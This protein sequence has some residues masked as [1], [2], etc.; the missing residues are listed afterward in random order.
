MKR[1]FSPIVYGSVISVAVILVVALVLVVNIDRQRR[2]NEITVYRQFFKLETERLTSRFKDITGLHGVIVN[3]P[4]ILNSL[5]R[6]GQGQEP[7]QAAAGMIHTILTNIATIDHVLAAYLLDGSGTCVFSSRNDF[8]GKNYGFRPYF[9][10]ALEQGRATYVAR[11]ITSRQLGIYFSRRIRVGDRLL[12]VAVLKLDPDFFD[13]TPLFSLSARPDGNKGS[14]RVG[15]V[16][17]TGLFVDVA[18]GAIH[19][20]GPMDPETAARIR[21][22]RQM[23]MDDIRPL[24]FAAGTWT[25]VRQAG[26]LAAPA[27]GE[28]YYLFAAPLDST[29][30][31]F[32]HVVRTS[33]FHRNYRQH[34]GFYNGLLLVFGCMLVLAC[35]L[36]FFLERRHRTV[37]RQSSALA[38]SEGKLRLF[39]QAVEQSGNSMVITDREGRIIYVNPYFCENTG[40]SREEVLGENPRILKSGIHDE[41]LYT[42]L[43]QTIT[44]GRTW[45]GTLCNRKKNGE[46]FWEE[47]TISPIFNDHGEITHYIAIK[48]DITERRNISRRLEEESDKLQFVVEYAGFGIAIIIDRRF[49]WVNRSGVKMFGYETVEEVLGQPSE[50]VYPDRESYEM[51]GRWFLDPANRNRIFKKE[52][53]L[54]K[55]DGTIFWVSLNGKALDSSDP[56]RGV[57]WIVDDITRRKRYEEELVRAQREAEAASEMKSRLLANISH[58]IRTPLHGIMGTFDLM[59]DMDLAPE[60]ARLVVS[61]RRAADFL[62]NLLNN[63]LD[64]SKIEAGQLVLDEF[65]FSIREL[66]GEVGEMLSSQFRRKGIRFRYTVDREV[67]RILVADALRIKQIFINLTGNSLKFTSQGEIAVMVSVKQQDSRGVLLLCQ[68]RDT[69]EGIPHGQQDRLFEAFTQADPSMRRRSAGTGLGLSICR[70]LCGL[71]GGR[72]WFESEPGQGTTFFFT[73]TCSTVSRQEEQRAMVTDHMEE[74]NG[75][76]LTILIVDDNEANR[77]ILRIILEQD[78]HRVRNAA[79]GL[80]ALQRMTRERFDLVFMDMQMPVMDG[81]TATRIIRHCEAETFTTDP[82][83][84]QLYGLYDELMQRLHQRIRGSRIPIVALTANAMQDDRERCRRAGMDAYLAKPFQRSQLLHILTTF[85]GT[86]QENDGHDPEADR[87]VPEQD[88]PVRDG[89][90]DSGPDGGPEEEG[91]GIPAMATVRRFLHS[92]YPFSEEQVTTLVTTTL[93]GIGQDLDRLAAAVESGE[94]A[95]IGGIAHKMKGSF[96]NLGLS[97]MAD[98]VAGME[99]ACKQGTACDHGAAMDELR[100]QWRLFLDRA[101]ADGDPAVA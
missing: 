93:Q 41:A 40:F 25:R 87:N 88:P 96:L 43:W 72:I 59:Q 63:L 70:E 77:D 8:I 78:G 82:D 48:E 64:L 76:G 15:L 28:D 56:G 6:I 71:M 65:P 85:F 100:R 50:M 16:T 14:L 94:E 29:D 45:K 9:T 22:L 92:R 58:D 38:E 1:R 7:S 33:W 17:G 35:L 99:Q 34:L 60:P 11:G 12:G 37:L 61:G 53:R 66:I 49:A 89:G 2:A 73:I 51:V 95:T 68:V 47:A 19:T 79:D 74:W 83:L 20:L 3:D 36:V 13:I 69:G 54:R 44:G 57:I 24:P 55:R 90:P 42:D 26:F 23:P 32:L 97:A 67:P 30:L 75:P 91:P 4:V 46:L 39:S 18:S 101:K 62:L 21:K 31:H 81:L 10:R 80:T 84:E 98:I 52:M 27:A 86:G 5:A